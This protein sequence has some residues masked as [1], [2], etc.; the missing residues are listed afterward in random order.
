MGLF[1]GGTAF[2]TAVCVLAICT[3][4][5]R[6]GN[7]AGSDQAI[8]ANPS[9]ESVDVF[10]SASTQEQE[11]ELGS[12]GSSYPRLPQMERSLGAPVWTRETLALHDGQDSQKPLLLAV[13]GEV[14][15]VGPGAQFYG[16]AGG[17]HA[18]AGRDGSRSLHTGEFDPKDVVATV[19]DLGDEALKDVL[20]W[21]DFYR[22]HDKYR[23]V[24]FLEGP[25]FDKEGKPTHEHDLV[26][27]KH[28]VIADATV[29]LQELRERFKSC[30]QRSHS[31]NTFYEIWC[32][33]SYHDGPG[34][35]P[36]HIAFT[37]SGQN[38]D[39]CTCL[40]QAARPVV[41]EEARNRASGSIL[42]SISLRL[43][44]YGH[45]TASQQRCQI[46]KGTPVPVQ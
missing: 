13:L 32:D 25:Y 19:S 12:E 42:T 36:V 41:L 11:Q 7:E 26:A 28:N 37:V 24:G 34:S 22:T 33:D 17:Y 29:T 38:H 3:Y 46:P 30:N 27:K 1:G 15:D 35:T 23:F 10:G 6:Q 9:V 8:A 40:T 43:A 45:C 39:W 2:A 18:L 31:E 20:D 21:R 4:Y 5:W 44:E 16:P 14:Y